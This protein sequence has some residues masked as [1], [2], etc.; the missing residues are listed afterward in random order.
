MKLYVYGPDLLGYF[1][2]HERHSAVARDGQ[3]RARENV[4]SWMARYCEVRGC[5]GWVYF[6]DAQPGEMRDPRQHVGPVYAVNLPYGEKAWTEMAAQANRAAAQER[7]VVVTDDVRLVRALTRGGATVAG[8]EEFVAR[9]RKSMRPEQE[10]LADEPDEKFT[11]LS[12][13]EVN[14][15]LDFFDGDQ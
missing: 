6:D 5:E 12:E 4:V 3:E 8:A 15:W 10:A 2:E 7:T 1:A 11:G 9:A 14:F 13:G